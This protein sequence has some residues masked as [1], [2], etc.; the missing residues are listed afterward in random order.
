MKVFYKQITFILLLGFFI[1]SGSGTLTSVFDN[2]PFDLYIRI[3]EI[4]W[5]PP[6]EYTLQSETEA[7]Y[8][9]ILVCEI[10]NPSKITYIHHT[11]NLNLI[12]PQMEIEL[13]EDYPIWADYTFWIFLT[14]H[15]IRPG[16]TEKKAIIDI[17]V[18]NY[19]DSSPPTGTY[20]V[21]GGIVGNHELYGDPP[22]TCKAYKTIIKH[23]RFRSKISYEA[24]PWNW[25]KNTSFKYRLVT[26][27]L[28]AF[29][30]GELIAVVFFWRKNKKVKIKH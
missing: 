5:P 6:S 3:T 19:N 1:T 26:I 10:W 22:F 21:W 13:K 27:F 17:T 4:T 14:T 7:G 28:W 16:V 2:K 18:R 23:N 11:P 15:E 8:D 24:A 30:G 9:I 29:S 25:G 20:T 12:D